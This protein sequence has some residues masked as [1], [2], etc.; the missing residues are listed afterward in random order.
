M[1]RWATA[2]MDVRRGR[3]AAVTTIG[4]L[5][6]RSRA[7]LN[8][9]PDI[10]WRDPYLVGF[11]LT[12]ITIVA[13]IESRSL[14]D[15]DLSLVQSQAWKAITDM[16]ADLVGE[17]ALTLSTSHPREFQHGCDCA[18]RVASRLCG[19]SAV[20]SIGYEPWPEAAHAESHPV[21]GDER[22]MSTNALIGNWADAFDA[23][24][25]TFPSAKLS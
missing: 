13:R 20:A 16:D 14:Q 7:R 5:V 24:I 18:T 17:D 19:A 15:R 25:A 3:R 21:F 4:P 8:G 10:A 2:M 23:H 22:G 12:L 1:L 11:M 6:E 9:I